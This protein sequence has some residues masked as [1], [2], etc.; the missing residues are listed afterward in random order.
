MRVSHD[1]EL[2]GYFVEG[3]GAE[4]KGGDGVGGA[5]QGG[6]FRSRDRG[7]PLLT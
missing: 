2:P 1:L 5:G 3:R 4:L 6:V 7:N